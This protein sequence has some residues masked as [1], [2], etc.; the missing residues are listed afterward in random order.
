M[1]RRA[2]TANA[3]GC[4]MW[5]AG[6]LRRS[7]SWRRLSRTIP[8]VRRQVLGC[9]HHRPANIHRPAGPQPIQHPSDLWPVLG[10]FKPIPMRF[11]VFNID[12]DLIAWIR[13]SARWFL[14]DVAVH[15]DFYGHVSHAR[16]PGAG[17][18]W[19][20]TR[21]APPDAGPVHLLHWFGDVTCAAKILDCRSAGRDGAIIVD[22]DE[23]AR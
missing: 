23:A 12:I 22:D 3:E 14:C 15:R 11:N 20:S 9:R 17:A 21:F 10:V 8:H 7:A 2:L 16:G 5:I 13:V 1:S 4:K 6:A 18:K 19:G